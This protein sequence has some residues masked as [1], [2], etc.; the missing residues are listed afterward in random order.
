MANG[1]VGVIRKRRE[2]KKRVVRGK[3]NLNPNTGMALFLCVCG[4]MQGRYSLGT[5]AYSVSASVHDLNAACLS[6]STSFLCP[7]FD[8]V[9]I[10]MNEVSEYRSDAGRL[11]AN[12]GSCPFVKFKYFD[13]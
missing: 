3:V 5:H 12:F 4:I 6:H 1:K 2:N 11:V 8:S 9:S 10:G 7:A 13:A